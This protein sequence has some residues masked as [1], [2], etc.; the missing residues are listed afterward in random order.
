MS[1]T[2]NT[3][4]RQ[5]ADKLPA[6][7][8]TL[9]RAEG[10]AADAELP[11]PGVWAAADNQLRSWALTAPKDGSYHRVDFVVDIADQH[12]YEGRFDLAFTSVCDLGEHIRST[13]AWRSNPTNAAAIGIEPTPWQGL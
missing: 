5:T 1:S 13:A 7:T 8:I 10:W 12:R 6:I 9:H 2:T 11:A 4:S 3:G